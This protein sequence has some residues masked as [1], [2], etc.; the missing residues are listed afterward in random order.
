[1]ADGVFKSWLEQIE[2]F[3]VEVIY[4]KR[5]G[6]RAYLLRIFLLLLSKLF[7]WLVQARLYLYQNRILRDRT[8]GCLVI[9]VGNLTVGGTGKTPVVEKIARALQE[10]GRR[11]AILSR[12]YKSEPKPFLERC[13]QRIT[14]QKEADEPRVVSNGQDLLLDSTSAGDEPYMLA[15]NL[16]DV[17]VLVDKDRVKSGRYA[18]EKLGIDTLLLDDG[19]QYLALKSK[20]NIVLVDCTNPF[21]NHY[22]LP[23]GT[24]REPHRNLKRADYIFI[25][26]LEKSG[27]EDLKQLIRKYNSHAEIIE[28]GHRPLYFQNVYDP[29]DR[30]PLSFIKGKKISSICG[31]ALP[32]SFEQGLVRLGAEL[33]YSKQYADHH[34]FSQQ[35]ILNMINRSRKRYAEVIVTTEKDAV[36]FPKMDRADVPLYFLRV[37]IEILSGAKDFDDCVSRIC[38][39]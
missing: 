23:R 28:C 26:K 36:R 12:G 18:I 3:A 16:R 7:E 5:R 38:F 2:Q 13:W 35:E 39:H 31:I 11:V 4:E 21:G 15:S 33:I 24:L 1:M 20:L 10:R 19:F 32:D 34:R 14:F 30:K 29:D 9:S 6:K 37:E 22:L 17:V 27:N 25:T 8:L